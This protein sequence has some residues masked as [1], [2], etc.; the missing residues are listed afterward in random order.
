[1]EDP[2]GTMYFTIKHFFL[3]DTAIF[4]VQTSEIKNVYKNVKGFL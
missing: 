1:M 3:F 4:W 2:Y